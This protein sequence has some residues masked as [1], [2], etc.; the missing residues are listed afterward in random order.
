MK[1]TPRH[2]KVLVIDVGGTHVKC[3]ATGE[4]RRRKF[5][6][7]PK[8]AP[9]AMVKS[10]MEMTHD[11]KFDPYLITEV[12]VQFIA[13]AADV[14]RVE[15]EHRNLERFGAQADAV[16]A[17]YDSPGGWPGLLGAFAACC[18]EGSSK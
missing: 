10:V 18:A 11:W 16:R 2:P 9:A 7:G 13:E 12:E 4:K 3:L 17:I 5:A 14:T 1:P 8:L 15:L 6:S